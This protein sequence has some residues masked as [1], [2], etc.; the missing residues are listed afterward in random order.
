VLGDTELVAVPRKV[1]EEWAAAE[2]P[3]PDRNFRYR[4]ID[5]NGKPLKA[6]PYRE[7]DLDL[8]WDS[9]DIAH[10]LTTK[11]IQKFVADYQTTLRRSA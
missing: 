11:G 1:L 4:G 8:A 6:I 2:F 10:E 3:M 9:F 5:A 7:F